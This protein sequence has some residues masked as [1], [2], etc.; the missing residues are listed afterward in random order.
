MF[1]RLL[2]ERAEEEAQARLDRDDSDDEE[3][4][5]DCD[6][7]SNMSDELTV[8]CLAKFFVSVFETDKIPFKLEVENA[9]DVL[10]ALGKRIAQ[11]IQSVEGYAS[12]WRASGV[13]GAVPTQNVEEN[14]RD[15]VKTHLHAW[16]RILEEPT[17]ER[18][19][20]RFVKAFPL[21]FPMGV[22]DFYQPRLRSDFTT[23]DAVQHLFRYC[24]GHLHRANDGNR[25]TW[26]L[27]NTALREAS[28]DKG[29]LV[30]KNMH[31]TV[32]TKA[33]LRNLYET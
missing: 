11:E 1:D 19:D 28:Y 4:K 12:I 26:A 5:H 16:P 15:H 29:G 21:V 3:H 13:M 6:I 17:R 31:E 24:T 22:A 18:A 30:H 27:F 14:T 7:G 2:I 23:Q 25:A 8:P 9:D 33:E 20:G 32:L 10:V